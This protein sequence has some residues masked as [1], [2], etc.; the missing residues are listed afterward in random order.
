MLLTLATL[1]VLAAP[2][3]QTSVPQA[4]EAAPQVQ[5]TE[6]YEPG[7]DQTDIAHERAMERAEDKFNAAMKDFVDG[8]TKDWKAPL[9][10]GLAAG[11][12]A[13]VLKQ[14]VKEARQKV[15]KNKKKMTVKAPDIR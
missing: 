10:E 2:T 9:K 11:L 15:A 3:D 5:T 12:D 8:K 4:V 1:A 13:G 6:N 7:E 14:R